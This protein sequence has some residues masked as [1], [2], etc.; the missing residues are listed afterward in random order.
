MPVIFESITPDTLFAFSI[1]IKGTNNPT[2]PIADEEL[3]NPKIL[4]LA[5]ANKK[6]MILIKSLITQ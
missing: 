5:F 2:K 3:A 6:D 1:C 4:L